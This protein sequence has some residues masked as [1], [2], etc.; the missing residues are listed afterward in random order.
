MFFLTAFWLHFCPPEP[1]FYRLL[2][3]IFNN[4]LQIP[5]RRATAANNQE[6]PK[7]FRNLDRNIA[8]PHFR[9]LQNAS[10]CNKRMHQTAKLQNGGAAVLAPHGAFGSAGPVLRGVTA[11]RIEIRILSDSKSLFR[12]PPCPPT[13]AWFAQFSAAEP[14]MSDFWLTFCRSEIHR[15]SDVS[16]NT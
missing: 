5:E 4:I 15:K 7:T 13:R 2:A 8:L 1:P 12:T 11:C 14:Q 3:P 6:L 10:S 9:V 16:K